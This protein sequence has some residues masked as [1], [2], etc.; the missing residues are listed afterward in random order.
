MREM[1]LYQENHV[2][3]MR[4]QQKQHQTEIKNLQRSMSELKEEMKQIKERDS[5]QGP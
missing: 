5:R 1:K 2:H 4:D 3:E